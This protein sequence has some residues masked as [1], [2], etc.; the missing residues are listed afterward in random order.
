MRKK[1]VKFD[2]AMNSQEAV[3]EWRTGSFHLVLMDLQLP[4]KD[5][6]EAT[7]EIRE[8]KRSVNIDAFPTCP[9]PPPAL[10]FPLP[11]E[12]E[13]LTLPPQRPHSVPVPPAELSYAKWT[14]WSSLPRF[15]T[16]AR[17][18]GRPQKV[19]VSQA[20]LFALA[21]EV[22]GRKVGGDG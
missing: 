2:I 17:T 22:Y 20:K 14:G 13:Q 1:S 11:L 9:S 21:E 5:G 12:L 16:R 15:S 7:K 6:I 19:F 8:A 18:S 10:P 3:D 4:V